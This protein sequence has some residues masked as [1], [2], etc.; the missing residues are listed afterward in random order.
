MGNEGM[1][2]FESI[3]MLSADSPG[4]LRR[5]DVFRVLDAARDKGCL[6]GF[7]EWLLSHDLSEAVRGQIV[8]VRQ[9]LV[10]GTSQA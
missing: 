10:E 3:L 8:K 2:K 4:Q 9:E 1:T 5:S 6:D 7:C